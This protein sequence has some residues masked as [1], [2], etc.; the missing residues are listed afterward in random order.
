MRDHLRLRGKPPSSWLAAGLRN[1]ALIST[2]N[3]SWLRRSQAT[4]RHSSSDNWALCFQ[5]TRVAVVPL[6]PR[7]ASSKVM[8]RVL[9]D[10]LLKQGR[11]RL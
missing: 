11:S 9:R 7:N 5:V 4:S 10:E 3:V 1:T 8:R 2:R 6:L